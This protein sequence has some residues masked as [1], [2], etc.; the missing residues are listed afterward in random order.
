MVSS[1]AVEVPP[2]TQTHT[3]LP[4]LLP[5]VTPLFFLADSTVGP[6]RIFIIHK[7]PLKY[8]APRYTVAK[9]LIKKI[10]GGFKLPVPPSFLLPPFLQPLP[11]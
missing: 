7:F 8:T 11:P 2:H 5:D 4:F 10:R 6:S 9:M 1:V 3:R